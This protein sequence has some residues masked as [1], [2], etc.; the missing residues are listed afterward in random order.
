MGLGSKGKIGVLGIDVFGIVV[1][2]VAV[3]VV[4]VVIFGSSSRIEGSATKEESVSFLKGNVLNPTQ[5]D[6]RL[7]GNCIAGALLLLLAGPAI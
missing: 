7:S 2:V 6:Q 1:V 3:I 4:A 5:G